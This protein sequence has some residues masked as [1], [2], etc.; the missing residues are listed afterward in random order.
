MNKKELL[1]LIENLKID[2]EE[3][4]IL[5]T[6]ALVLRNIYYTARDLDIAVTKKGL[7]KL[8]NSYNLI[9]QESG[10]YIVND[11]VECVL[12]D[13][14][15]KKIKL[16]K[17]YVQD[18]NDYLKFLNTSKR[19]KDK[20][21][22]PIVL[23][24]INNKNTLLSNIDKVHTTKL[25]EERIKN[26]LKLNINNVVDYLKDKI[27]SKE[28]IIYKKGKNYYCEIDNIKITINSYNYSIIT[29]HI[30]K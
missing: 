3:F 6:G 23:E 2:I 8:K 28:C 12:D 27:S 16:G 4:T 13:M 25:G 19:E 9:Q 22:I 29:A 24:Y 11:K 10:W 7:K 20:Q 30:I 26:N 14:I 1:N 5:S 18:I 21:K 15:N 17:Y